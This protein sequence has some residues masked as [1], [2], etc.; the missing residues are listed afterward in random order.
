MEPLV[1]LVAVLI[2][3][4]GLIGVV[5]PVLPGLLVV[6]V[7]GVGSTLLVGTD[8]AGWAVAGLLTVLFGMGTAATLWLPARHG[9]RGGVPLR[10]LGTAAAGAV[11]GFFVIPIVGFLVGAALGLLVAERRRLGDWQPAWRSVGGI[12]RA[13]GIGVVVELVVGVSM[14]AVWAAAALLR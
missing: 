13:Y 4:V 14:I 8:L 1:A 11:I 9:R 12:V 2:M 6:W 10:S 5:V 7:A 3:L